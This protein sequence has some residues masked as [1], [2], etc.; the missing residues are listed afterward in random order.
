MA[1]FAAAAG[2]S[3]GA[4]VISKAFVVS[5]LLCATVL[6]PSATC[7]VKHRQD[8]FASYAIKLA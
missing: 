7:L 6:D 5:Y 2:G 3:D 8:G 1:C 4:E